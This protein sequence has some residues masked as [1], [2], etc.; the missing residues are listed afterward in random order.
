MNNEV[1]GRGLPIN[2]AYVADDSRP[3]D[4]AA[5][6]A[7]VAR[8]GGIMLLSPGAGTAAADKQIDQLG[9]TAPS[10]R[11]SSSGAP[12]P[13]QLPVGPSRL[14]RATPSGKQGAKGV[15]CG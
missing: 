9:L 8:T 13:P 1:K 3:V 12:A 11:S 2:V 5:A 7:A 15:N 10:T 6:A 14:R 4:A